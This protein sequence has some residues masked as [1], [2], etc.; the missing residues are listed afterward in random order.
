MTA[1]PLG[2]FLVL[3]HVPGRGSALACVCLALGIVLTPSLEPGIHFWPSVAILAGLAAAAMLG[4]TLAERMSR[5]DNMANSINQGRWVHV[6]V[7]SQGPDDSG[8]RLVRPKVSP[9]SPERCLLA[10]LTS[11]SGRPSQTR[12]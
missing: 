1:M 6:Y 8:G 5:S 10:R 3:G 4:G 7:E 2:A 12:A 9:H 11:P